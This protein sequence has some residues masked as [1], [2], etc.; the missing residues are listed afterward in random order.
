METGESEPETGVHST[1]VVNAPVDCDD[2]DS[3][4]LWRA[5]AREDDG[6]GVDVGPSVVSAEGG[7]DV[8]A[9]DSLDV[10]AVDGAEEAE[11]D[12]VPRAWGEAAVEAICV[13]VCE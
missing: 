13:G 3:L 8:A 4:G 5:R 1:D 7:A 10:G 6:S 9:L 12:A 2:G 11:G